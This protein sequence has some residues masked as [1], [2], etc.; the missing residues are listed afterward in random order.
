[1]SK[2]VKSIFIVTIVIV[3]AANVRMFIKNAE[4]EKEVMASQEQVK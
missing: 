2:M 1:M 3:F 4:L